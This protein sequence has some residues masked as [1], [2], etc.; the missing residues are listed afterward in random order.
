[1]CALIT[2][3]EKLG[4]IRVISL[5]ILA[6]EPP[7]KRFN[8]IVQQLRE[9]VDKVVANPRKHAVDPI[10]SDFTDMCR[11]APVEQRKTISTMLQREVGHPLSYF[12]S[13]RI[14]RINRIAKRGVIRTD[15][16][17]RLVDERLQELSQS[18]EAPAEREILDRLLWTYKPKQKA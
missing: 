4:Y 13:A 3:Q 6:E 10:F 9:V 11:E 12:E 8:A 17:W 1:M 14:H 18:R 5:T 16:E 15:D 2:Q 7:D